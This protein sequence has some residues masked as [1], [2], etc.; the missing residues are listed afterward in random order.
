MS[1]WSY[2]FFVGNMLVCLPKCGWTKPSNLDGSLISSCLDPFLG[3]S[4]LDFHIGWPTWSP[5]R[6]PKQICVADKDLIWRFP[7]MVAP[8]HS[9]WFS[10]FPWNKPS[11]YWGI[12]VWR[13]PHM[14]SPWRS[15]NHQG[16]ECR[17]NVTR[18]AVVQVPVGFGHWKST[19]VGGRP[20]NIDI[21]W[22]LMISYD[23]L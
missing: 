1:I 17:L 10:D 6:I 9:I 13:N 3:W 2:H 16:Y 22:W 15:T 19:R 4:F 23:T 8:N 20:V 12:P 18:G 21:V 14:V 11:S 7:W 5:K